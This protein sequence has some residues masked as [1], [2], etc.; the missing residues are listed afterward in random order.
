MSRVPGPDRVLDV[1]AA[2]YRLGRVADWAWVAR[3]S[4][5]EVFRLACADRQV[6]AKRLFWDNGDDDRVRDEIAFAAKC[7]A[8]GVNSP[9]TLVDPGGD[10]L[11]VDP[12]TGDRWRLQEWVDGVVAERTDVDAAGW[13]AEQVAVIHGLAIPA[14]ADQ[15]VSGWFGRVDDEWD[16]VLAATDACTDACTDQWATTLRTRVSEFRELAALVDAVP[17]G[18]LVHC[19]RDALAANTMLSAEG[20]RWLIDWENH[21]AME[22]WREVGVLLLHHVQSPETVAAIARR[23]R[24]A[25]AAPICREASSCSRLD[26]P[27]G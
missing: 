11:F 27:S 21:G 5:G 2:H 17:L 6:A 10:P 3:G 22:P 8:A 25:A 14:P 23:Y 1:V 12:E 24:A 19:H 26:W 13:L 4:M 16:A 20:R 7:R 9:A 15:Y 18:D